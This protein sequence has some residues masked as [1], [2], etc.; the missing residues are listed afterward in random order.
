MQQDQIEFRKGG[1]KGAEGQATLDDDR[2][3]E[4][5]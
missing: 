3:A 5:G 4:G 2:L 1:M